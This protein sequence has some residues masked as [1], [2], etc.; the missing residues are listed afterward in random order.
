MKLPY[1]IVAID[2]E[3]NG[4]DPA[5]ASI[6]EFGAVVIDEQL[7]ILR[8]FRTYIKPL[9]DYWSEK[10][11]KVNGITKEMLKDAPTLEDALASHTD[12]LSDDWEVVE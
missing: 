1:K 2:L 8:E 11:E 3:T 10:A 5:V 6:L 9:D 12:L 7:N 4:L